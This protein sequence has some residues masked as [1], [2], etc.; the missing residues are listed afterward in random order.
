M[1]GKLD[2]VKALL[3][4]LLNE[5]QQARADIAWLKQRLEKQP[6]PPMRAVITLPESYELGEPSIS[7]N[8]DEWAAV[9]RGDKFSK[10]GTGYYLVEGEIYCWDYWEF[11]GGICGMIRFF[12]KFEVDDEFELEIEEKFF[13]DMVQ[14][15][16]VA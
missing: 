4:E 10:L 13:A 8:V 11:E 3:N 5:M 1:A 6:V 14:E 15:F 16:S 7:L 12:C 2:E 9:K